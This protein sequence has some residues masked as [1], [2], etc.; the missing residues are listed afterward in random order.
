[1]VGTRVQSIG[2]NQARA[3]AGIAALA[4]ANGEAL[5]AN[6][7]D[8]LSQWGAWLDGSVSFLEGK[9]RGARFDGDGH[10]L[11]IGLDHTVGW[12]TVGAAISYA[13][14]GLDLP[15]VRGR[16]MAVGT[17]FTPYVAAQITQNL[18]LGAFVGYTWLDNE[19]SRS[20]QRFGD[21]TSNYSGHRVGGGV[22]LSGAYVFNAIVVA[23]YLSY[24]H[25]VEKL[26]A[27]TDRAGVRVEGSRNTIGLAR[28]GTEVGYHYQGWEP[29]VGV[30]GEYETGDIGP[31]VNRFGLALSAG[32]R[33][34]LHDQ[35]RLAIQATT[36][37]LK[38]AVT[39]RSVAATLRIRF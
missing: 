14:T 30:G 36:V 22:V 8:G 13:R 11:A 3:R 37:E 25:A 34:A 2:A 24:S 27:Y 6:G 1:M 5:G 7:G 10:A 38:D 29:F 39:D 4:P 28:L 9:A 21:M 12:L 33:F 26:S 23:P 16:L 17:S 19:F 31:E 32:L 20:D 18:S 35:V 15:D